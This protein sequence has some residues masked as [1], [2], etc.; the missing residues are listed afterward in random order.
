MFNCK[1]LR[2]TLTALLPRRS[3]LATFSQQLDFHGLDIG[4]CRAARLAGPSQPRHPRPWA[5]PSLRRRQRR[6]L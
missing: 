2:F 5:R 6:T 4:F 3:D 1:A